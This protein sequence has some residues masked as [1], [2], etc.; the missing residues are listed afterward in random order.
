VRVTLTVPLNIPNLFRNPKNPGEGG[1]NGRGGRLNERGG[2][3]NER[4]G[5]L[6]KGGGG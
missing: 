6:N 5:V 4:G 2:G 3:M 1:L